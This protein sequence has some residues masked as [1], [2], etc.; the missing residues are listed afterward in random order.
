MGPLPLPTLPR[1]ALAPLWALSWP[2]GSS[3][4]PKGRVEPRQGRQIGR[5]RERRGARGQRERWEEAERR[6]GGGER[7]EGRRRGETAAGR[8][9][10]GQRNG[11][12]EGWKDRGGTTHTGEAQGLGVRRSQSGSKEDR[13]Y[14]R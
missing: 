7:G 5:K 9:R 3:A 2:R 1:P 11:M 12:P 4:N 13:R 6:E 10:N 8:A 14:Q